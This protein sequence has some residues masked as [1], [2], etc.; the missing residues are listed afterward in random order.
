MKNFVAICMCVFTLVACGTEE[1]P[2]NT[3]EP[4]LNESLKAAPAKASMTDD[5]VFA[6]ILGQEYGLPLYLNQPPRIGEMLDLDA[7]VQGIVDNEQVQKD[8]GFVL[9]VLPEE[10]RALEAR[11]EQVTKEREAL[12]DNAKPV[13]L[14]GPITGGKVV[15][16]D[17]TA[18]IIKY[19]YT[20]GVVID[21]F[22]AGMSRTFGQKFDERYFI[23]GLRESVLAA[24]DPSFKRSVS[25]DTLKAVNARFVE[26]ME[27]IRKEQR[28]Q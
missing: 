14:A 20:R 13:V 22:F 17:T 23:M 28:G 7:M 10:Q 19:S 27:E 2:K 25:D 26:R 16:A 11:Y 15:I 4:A 24:M 6:Y 18:P 8:T 3:R 21:G 9:Q 1:Q 12:G 5:Q